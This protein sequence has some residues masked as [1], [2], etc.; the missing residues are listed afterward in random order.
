M[1]TFHP[2]LEESKN[3]DPRFDITKPEY[4]KIKKYFDLCIVF[5]KLQTNPKY[6]EN[7]TILNW[8]KFVI[9]HH[10]KGV[11]CIANTDIYNDETKPLTTRLLENTILPPNRIKIITNNDISNALDEAK[12][13]FE[14]WSDVDTYEYNNIVDILKEIY[15]ID[16]FPTIKFNEKRAIRDNRFTEISTQYGLVRDIELELLKMKKHRLQNINIYINSGAGSGKTIAA[17]YAYKYLIKLGKKPIFVCYNHLLGNF[18][19]DNLIDHKL[20]GYIGT[21]Y[22]FAKGK[23]HDNL[24][25][26]QNNLA[27]VVPD[28]NHVRFLLDKIKSDKLLDKPDIEKFNIKS[29]DQ[30]DALIVDEGQ[31]FKDY[32]VELLSLYLKSDASVLWFEDKNQTIID[33]FDHTHCGLASANTD[34]LNKINMQLPQWILNKPNYR[35]TAH[36]ENFLIIFFQEYKLG[37][38]PCF[39]YV[40][41]PSNIRI[42]GEN[43]K[44]NFYEKGCLPEKLKKRIDYLKNYE[45]IELNDIEII[46]CLPDSIDE[47]SHSL[48]LEKKNDSIPYQ[49]ILKEFGGYS[50]KR[51]TGEYID[52]RKVY[53]EDNGIFCESITRYKGMESPVILVVDVEKPDDFSDHDW[54]QLLYCSLTRATMH[55]EVFVCN[56]GNMSQCFKDV[57]KIINKNEC[58]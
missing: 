16:S 3:Y 23:I 49:Y 34:V 35:T 50:L 52:G 4:T 36:I 1:T 38:M 7:P 12:N 8:F 41:K 24:R 46:S 37:N 47:P 19:A 25:T 30:Y 18:L 48:L 21:I 10:K 2:P 11:I 44:V 28:G 31:D 58:A 57:D 17:I 54:A 6:L 5:H 15:Q 39:N 53:K 13:I 42:F 55:M 43:V 33:D 45:H 56:E 51:L 40:T 26:T 32:W 9:V 20:S 14:N 29:I 22:K 27:P